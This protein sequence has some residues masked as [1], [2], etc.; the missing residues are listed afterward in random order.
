MGATTWVGSLDG[1]LTPSTIFTTS[2]ASGPPLRAANRA[3]LN[4]LLWHKVVMRLLMNANL[5]V[6]G[7][8][9]LQIENRVPYKMMITIN[10][11]V[12]EVHITIGEPTIQVITNWATT[13]GTPSYQRG[14]TRDKSL[15]IEV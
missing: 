8:D 3:A 6:G 2:S 13:R 11:A 1:G 10:I 4:A 14:A 9:I 15:W 5:K 12:L 7:L